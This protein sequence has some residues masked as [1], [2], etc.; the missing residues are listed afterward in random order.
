M[1]SNIQQFG[2]HL[3]EEIVIQSTVAGAGYSL[4]SEANLTTER[5][6]AFCQGRVQI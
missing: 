2:M 3:S 6:G 1:Q 4:L 5:S